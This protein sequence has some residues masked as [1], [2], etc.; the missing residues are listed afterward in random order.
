MN[1]KIILN[2]SVI[3]SRS[4]NTTLLI[5]LLALLLLIVRIVLWELV[6]SLPLVWSWLINWRLIVRWNI[7]RIL[8]RGGIIISTTLGR[9]T[10]V[11]SMLL[12]LHHGLLW[13]SLLGILLRVWIKLRL[14]RLHRDLMLDDGGWLLDIDNLGFGSIVHNLLFELS[15]S[16]SL[17]S[18][19][20]L[21][22]LLLSEDNFLSIKLLLSGLLSLIFHT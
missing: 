21:L 3:A 14:L 6:L 19:S 10:S 15:D 8:V 11:W 16:I 18:L 13:V 22:L 7:S 12:G 20:L 4:F 9:H 2:V 17:L 1:V 5:I